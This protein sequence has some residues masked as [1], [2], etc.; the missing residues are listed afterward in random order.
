[1]N[2]QYTPISIIYLSNPKTQSEKDKPKFEKW[3]NNWMRT[4]QK[5]IY[6]WVIRSWN[7]FTII[8]HYGNYNIH[9]NFK[10]DKQNPITV[11]VDKDA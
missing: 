2:L 1:M 4:S 5:N 7:G 10:T 11:N 3:Q 6:K 8:S 9:Q